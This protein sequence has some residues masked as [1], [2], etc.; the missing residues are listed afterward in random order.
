MYR[1]HL[2]SYPVPSNITYHWNMG[3]L[4]LIS[5]IVQLLSGILL[6]LHYTSN[7]EYAWLSV[8]YILRE[9]Y[10]GWCI[11]YIHS[12][13][14]TVVMLFVYTHIAKYMYY[15]GVS[16]ITSLTNVWYSGLTMFL[17]LMCICFLGYVCIW[18][19]M[20][21]WGC[22]VILNLLST[23]PN[24]TMMINGAY[25]CSSDML[26][27]FFIFHFILPFIVLVLSITHFYYLHYSGSS[28][29]IS[30]PTTSISS[31]SMT[32][33]LKDITTLCLLLGVYTLLTGIGITTIIHPNNYLPIN[34][35]STPLSIV[36]EWYYLPYYAILKSIPNNICGYILFCASITCILTT[37][38]N[39]SNI[40]TTN[41]TTGK[42]TIINTAKRK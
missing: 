6:T 5:I 38:S 4:L 18:G 7:T 8:L 12:N 27:R 41:T 29:S 20:S 28:T 22:T 3:F 35:L 26:L 14:A 9:V 13:G 42:E 17:L 11:S 23:I 15:N 31:F 1:S 37:V 33:L 32:I 25:T 30:L 10:Y 21:Y 2:V 39:T 40:S 36:P 24:M 19:Q 34:I 16:N